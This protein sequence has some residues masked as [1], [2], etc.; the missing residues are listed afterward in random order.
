MIEFQYFKDCPNANETLKNLRDFM[1]NYN[2]PNDQLV[3]TLIENENMAR[4]LHFQGSPSILVNGIDLYTGLSPDNYR[5]SCRLYNIDGAITGVL[6][7]NYISSRY[8]NFLDLHKKDE[9]SLI[10]G[11]FKN[12]LKAIKISAVSI[13][14]QNCPK[15]RKHGERV[16][17]DTV[18]SLLKEDKKKNFIKGEYSLC[19]N[20]K[21]S[22][23]YFSLNSNRFYN[24]EDLVVPLWYKSDSKT[25]YA[26]Y[27]S[28]VTKEN[29]IE[30]IKTH[31]AKTVKDINKITGSMK[32]S[33]C[34][35]KNP[36]GKCCHNIIQDT[37][38][39]TEIGI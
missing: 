31:Q 26:C 7:T 16:K 27:C 34:L 30:A 32:N 14:S 12:S 19:M 10:T 21:C 9:Y 35:H 29:V 13:F 33:D 4:D 38:K 20:P 36:L 17:I 5:F 6:S 39:N 15:C 11:G 2:I 37:I 22:V 24:C 28:K 25:I 18:F 23:S 1:F 3:I 8:S